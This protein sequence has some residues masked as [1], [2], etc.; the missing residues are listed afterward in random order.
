MSEMSEKMSNFKS[1]QKPKIL[2]CTGAGASQES[3][4]PT[5]RDNIT[6]Y[7]SQYDPKY[8]ASSQAFELQPDEVN[9]FYNERRKNLGRCIPNYFH[10]FVAIIQNKYGSD[11]VAVMTTNVDDLHERTGVDV[12]KI[13]GNLTE[14][15]SF[16]GEVKNIGYRELVGE[17][18]KNNKPNVV[19]FGESG[20]YKRDHSYFSPY[21]E[22]QKIISS[23]NKEDLIFIVGCSSAVINFPALAL[24]NYKKPKIFIVNPNN[25]DNYK[26]DVNIIKKT[27][28]NA[29]PDLEDLISDHFKY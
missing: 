27:A 29:V 5:F 12:F 25:I 8:I 21:P 23:M 9:K 22:V 16:D 13:H 15:I 3:G 6:G 2:F 28:C 10:E 14:V 18:L 20:Y 26:K 11:Q 19:M 17:E 1:N 4:I 24:S 7:W